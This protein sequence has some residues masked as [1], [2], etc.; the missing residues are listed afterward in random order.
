MNIIRQFFSQARAQKWTRRKITDLNRLPFCRLGSQA[1][2]G[3]ISSFSVPRV[4]PKIKTVWKSFLKTAKMKNNFA[5]CLER[6]KK[7][8][9]KNWAFW[10]FHFQKAKMIIFRSIAAT[11]MFR[12]RSWI[13]QTKPR[14]YLPRDCHGTA[15]SHYSRKVRSRVSPRCIQN[16]LDLEIPA[17]KERRQ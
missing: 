3:S 6:K 15:I 2:G 16:I 11:E 14:F 1:S 10:P 12:F 8:T 5:K 17:R 9:T 7:T 4:S 13:I